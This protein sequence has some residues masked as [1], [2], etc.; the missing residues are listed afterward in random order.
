MKKIYKPVAA[1]A[2]ALLAFTGIAFAKSKLKVYT[3]LSDFSY[4]VE[5]IGKDKVS[6]EY[7]VAPYQNP[8]FQEPKPSFIVKLNKA[9][10]LIEAGLELTKA[11]L[12]PIVEQARNKDIV[13]GGKH[14]FYAYPGIDIL[15]VPERKLTRFEGD[16]HPAGNPHYN[17]DPKAMLQVSVNIKDALATVDPEGEKFYSDNQAAWGTGYEKAL[18]RWESQMAPW[19][20]AK[21]VM[22]H[23]SLRYFVMRYGLTETGTVEPKPGVTPSGQYL[24]DLT[25]KMKA[26]NCKVILYEPWDSKKFIETL[27]RNT[28]AVAVEISPGVG[29]PKSVTSIEQRWDYTIGKVLEAFKEAGYSPVKESVK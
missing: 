17:Y 13:P 29:S 26:Q 3:D 10:V 25:E 19:K 4:L 5:Q 7:F 20:G 24:A 27:A 8:H 1:V 22:Y 23:T 11:W 15:D 16:V 18:A 28:G 6:S 2:C 9:D 12:Q 21:I 14:H